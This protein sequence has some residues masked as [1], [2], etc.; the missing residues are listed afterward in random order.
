MAI[1]INYK[2]RS[3]RKTSLLTAAQVATKMKGEVIDGQEM[4]SYVS[5]GNDVF[6][7]IDP[8]YTQMS[9]GEEPLIY[10][11]W[12]KTKEDAENDYYQSIEEI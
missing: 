9:S 4:E 10:I 8:Y 2:G 11:R 12:A 6:C 7:Y 3:Y 5:K 1:Y